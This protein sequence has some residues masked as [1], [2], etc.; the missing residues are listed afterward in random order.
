MFSLSDKVAIVTGGSR[1]IGRAICVALARAGAKVVV[2]YAGNEDAAAETLRLVRE[3]GSDGELARFDVADPEAVD[4]A[5]SDVATA[6]ASSG[7]T[8]SAVRSNP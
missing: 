7:E 3:A 6:G 5:I 2:N 4:Q 1:G 8:E